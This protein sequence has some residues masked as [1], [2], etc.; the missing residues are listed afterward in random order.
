[1][2][3]IFIV[4][5]FYHSSFSQMIAMVAP[6]AET[7]AM[8]TI[9][10]YTFILA[11]SG[12]VQPLVQ[13]IKFWH[14]A[15]YV[16]P[17]TWLVSALMATGTHNTSV[18]CSAVEVNVFQPPEGKTCGEYASTFAAVAG[19]AVYNPQATSDCQYCRY[20]VAD[21][22]LQAYNMVWDDRWKNLGFLWVYTAFNVFAFFV[23]YWLHSEVRFRN[24]FGRA[25]K[26]MGSLL[27]H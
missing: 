19:G 16:S 25:K 27:H 6:N 23:A 11:F 2:W 18:Q 3:F 15:Y 12:V 21:V 10:F 26:L 8:L 24:I 7:A 4:Y 1:M 5:Q 17:F 14:F 22:F 20:A 9:L 13:L